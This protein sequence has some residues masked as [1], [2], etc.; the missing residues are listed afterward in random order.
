MKAE[1][2]KE[3]LFEQLKTFKSRRDELLYEDADTF[4]HHL[5][6]FLE[7]VEVNPIL[8]DSVASFGSHTFDFDKWWLELQNDR[9]SGRVKFPSDSTEEMA[10]RYQLMVGI[11]KDHGHLYT[12]GRHFSKSKL[13]EAKELF[14]T[15]VIKPLTDYL[16]SQ[17]AEA[18]DLATPEAVRM[19]ALPLNRIPGI[20]EDMLFLSHKSEDKPLVHRVYSVLLELGFKPWLDKPEMPAGT[21]LERGL[22]DGFDRSCAAVFFITE[23]FKDENYLASEIDYAIQQKRKKGKKFAIIT[24]RF[25]KDA[26]IPR[27]LETYVYRDVSDELDGLHEIILALPIELGSARWKE[28]VVK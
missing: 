19:Q 3:K 26:P 4:D 15:V 10:F 17:A 14:T 20:N 5:E 1:I 28:E 13:D 11:Q 12:F 6:R 16:S 8:T 7:H 9:G 23:N 22:I 21:N 25:N 18:V 27:L 24:I 2:P